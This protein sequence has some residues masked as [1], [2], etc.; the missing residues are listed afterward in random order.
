MRAKRWPSAGALGVEWPLRGRTMQCRSYSP[1]L[2]CASEPSDD[3]ELQ[4]LQ[5]RPHGDATP[6]TRSNSLRKEACDAA[7]GCAKSDPQNAAAVLVLVLFAVVVIS[8]M[9]VRDI[10]PGTWRQCDSSTVMAKHFYC[11]NVSAAPGVHGS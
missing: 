2:Q 4:E 9:V 1:R 8:I 6:T 7:V 5:R 11:F 3:E 10:T